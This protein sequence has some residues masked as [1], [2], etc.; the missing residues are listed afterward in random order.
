[1]HVILKNAL[2]RCIDCIGVNRSLIGEFT[3]NKIKLRVQKVID[4]D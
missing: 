4:E 2:V 1:M 3:K